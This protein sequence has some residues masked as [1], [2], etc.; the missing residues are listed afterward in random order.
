[1]LLTRRNQRTRIKARPS[2]TLST[3]NRTW[4]DTGVNPGLRVERPAT[5]CLSHGTAI[6]ELTISCRTRR[7]T[8]LNLNSIFLVSPSGSGLVGRSSLRLD[9]CVGG[10]GDTSEES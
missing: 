9:V 6:S 2:A 1:M 8:P 10:G 3:T 5:N 4:T 7:L